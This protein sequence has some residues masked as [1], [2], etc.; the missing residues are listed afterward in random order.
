MSTTYKVLART[1]FRGFKEGDT[2]EADLT[3]DQERRAKAR[4]SIRVIRR[5]DKHEKEEKAD[6]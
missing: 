4:G 6:G 3:E 5:D 1:G 2:F